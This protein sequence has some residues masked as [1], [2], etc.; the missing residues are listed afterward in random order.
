M[1]EIWVNAGKLIG[2]ITMDQDISDHIAITANGIFI[3][4]NVGG[5]F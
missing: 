1:L 4:L 2:S 3:V 5:N